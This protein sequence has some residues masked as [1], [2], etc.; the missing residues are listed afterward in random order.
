MPLTGRI[1]RQMK[2]IGLDCATDDARIGLAL[3]EYQ[4]SVVRV[5]TVEVCS[6][7]RKAASIISEWLDGVPEA[8]VAI[9]APLGWPVALARSL[10]THTAGESLSAL[11]EEMFRRR[12][13]RFIKKQIGK[14]PLEV[15]AD[16]IA[17]TAH[18]ALAILGDV[19]KMTGRSI[20]LAWEPS[21]IGD[22]AAI[23]VYPAAT[24]LAHGFPSKDYK[25]PGQSEERRHIVSRLEGVLK[26]PDNVLLMAENADALDAVVCLLAASDF[27]GG[28]SMSPPDL[29]LAKREGWIWARPLGVRDPG[30]THAALKPLGPAQPASTSREIGEFDEVT[31][32]DV[33]GK[34][35]RCPAC[36]EKVFA[37]WP[38]GWDAHVGSRCAGATGR[39]AEERK[40]SFKRQY[41]H[42]FR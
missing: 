31:A 40:D 26:L 30:M 18:A 15:G 27:L 29:E 35:V 20:P 39:T 6:R 41:R 9:D 8:V 42:L 14:T 23:E 36:R 3:G 28:R 24:L 37:S 5:L 38:L 25:K 19:R 21:N 33:S 11:P 17:R 32:G 22:V 16:R 1:G 10:I 13:D 4:G 34:R 2:V 12:T 7:D